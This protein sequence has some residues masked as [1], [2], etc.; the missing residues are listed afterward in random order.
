M[1]LLT[2]SCVTVFT[3]PLTWCYVTRH[4][5][6]T[7]FVDK[8]VFQ[9][10]ECLL[11]MSVTSFFYVTTS[12]SWNVNIFHKVTRKN[13]L[14]FKNPILTFT[15]SVCVILQ[16][17]ICFLFYKKCSNN[18]PPNLSRITLL[19][20]S[21]SQFHSIRP[22]PYRNWF[23]FQRHIEWDME[24]SIFDGLLCAALICGYFNFAVSRVSLKIELRCV[25]F[26]EGNWMIKT[27]R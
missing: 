3:L 26:T 22:L 23:W 8:V 18:V 10:N 11:M 20:Y 13:T 24:F 14:M 19:Y 7:S 16:F 1:L 15:S 21:I 9:Y 4:T 5:L 2:F 25:G 27:L 6:S 12:V 17:V